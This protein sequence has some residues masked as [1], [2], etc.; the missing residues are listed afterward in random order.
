ML[1][2]DSLS[3]GAMPKALATMTW[4]WSLS[5]VVNIRTVVD[6]SNHLLKLS[7]SLSLCRP[8]LLLPAVFPVVTIFSSASFL[9]TCPKKAAWPRLIFLH[10]ALWTPALF[11]TSSFVT[12]STYEIFCILL[13]NTFQQ[14]LW[15]CMWLHW[16]SKPCYCIWE[17]GL[18]RCLAL[19][20]WS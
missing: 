4:Y 6:V 8:L 20:A 16:C 9:I 12:L 2:N 15:S 1:S 3:Q 14:H 11:S 19:S 10:R 7:V 18:C 5:L 13:K 17:L